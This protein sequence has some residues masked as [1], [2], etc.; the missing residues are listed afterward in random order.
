MFESLVVVDL[1]ERR[2]REVGDGGEVKTAFFCCNDGVTGEGVVTIS[3][4]RALHPSLRYTS[5]LVVRWFIGIQ[6]S[7]DPHSF[8]S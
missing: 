6:P 5:W 2:E 4:L 1:A 7:A 8:N 3:A